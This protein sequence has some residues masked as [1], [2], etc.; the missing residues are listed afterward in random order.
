M[1]KLFI[2]T[3]YNTSTNEVDVYPYSFETEN[4]AKKHLSKLEGYSLKVINHKDNPLD[5]DFITADWDKI[6]DEFNKDGE[7]MEQSEK[8]WNEVINNLWENEK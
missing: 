4:K 7:E 8:Y 3:R 6:S 1:K 2:F 5:D